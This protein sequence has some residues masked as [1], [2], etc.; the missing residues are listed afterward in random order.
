M[1]FWGQTR[2]EVWHAKIHSMYPLEGFTG[3]AYLKYYKS[4]VDSL[5]NSLT[6]DIHSFQSRNAE[7]HSYTP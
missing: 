3:R 2:P 1:H 6:S 5:R 4:K 7:P